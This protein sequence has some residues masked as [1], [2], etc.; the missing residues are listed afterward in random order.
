MSLFII[1]HIYFISLLPIK[2]A[3]PHE[4]FKQQQKKEEME[5]RSGRAH[6]GQ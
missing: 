4:G 2:A 5:S 6:R 1:F 3:R